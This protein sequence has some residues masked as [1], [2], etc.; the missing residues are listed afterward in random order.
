MPELFLKQLGVAQIQYIGAIEMPISTNIWNDLLNKL[1][2]D[3]IN[4]GSQEKKAASQV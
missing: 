2:N 1:E 4:I 3:T